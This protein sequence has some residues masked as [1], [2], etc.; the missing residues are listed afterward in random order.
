MKH[1]REQLWSFVKDN[2]IPTPEEPFLHHPW[3]EQVAQIEAQFGDVP[4]NVKANRAKNIGRS[5]Y[6]DDG[7]GEVFKGT[8]DSSQ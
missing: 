8:S 6:I 5:I 7:A 3:V 4:E 2:S 1:K